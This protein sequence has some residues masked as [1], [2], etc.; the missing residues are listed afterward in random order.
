MVITQDKRI[1]LD[2]KGEK[3]DIASFPIDKFKTAIQKYPTIYY[4]MVQEAEPLIN[5]HV[6]EELKNIKPNKE[7]FRN[8]LKETREHI[9]S[10]IELLELD[11]IDNI[12]VKS[13]SV[14]YSSML[15][16]RGLFII[17]CILEKGNFS[18]KKFKNW[19]EA[20]GLNRREYEDCYKA[21]RLVRD[22]EDTKS[23][24]I[25]VQTAEKLLNILQNELDLLEKWHQNME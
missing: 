19:L 15:R 24:R 17:K 7:G 10:S 5:A 11:K 3:L 8:Y 22:N 6:L 18:N 9:K 1:K 16:L 14:I 12:Y 2:F 4:Q 21:Y 13:Y 25:N 20:K 23:L